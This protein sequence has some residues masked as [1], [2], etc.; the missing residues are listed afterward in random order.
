MPPFVRPGQGGR[1]RHPGEGRASARASLGGTTRPAEAAVCPSRPGG[2]ET[3]Q[4]APGGRLRPPPYA[5]WWWCAV[6]CRVVMNGSGSGRDGLQ[7]PQTKPQKTIHAVQAQGPGNTHTSRTS[8]TPRYGAASTAGQHHM[9]PAKALM[10]PRGSALSAI[11]EFPRQPTQSAPCSPEEG[12]TGASSSKG[13][14]PCATH[15]CPPPPPAHGQAR[16][17]PPQQEQQAPP[18]GASP[19]DPQPTQQTNPPTACNPWLRPRTEAATNYPM[20]GA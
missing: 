3:S 1:R 18:T 19:P 10:H 6:L 15:P 11:T 12:R 8:R 2:G 7:D 5:R 20:Q 9:P 16:P 13:I 14:H 4:R 17:A